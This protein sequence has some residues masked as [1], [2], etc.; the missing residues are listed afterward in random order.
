MTAGVAD[1]AAVDAVSVDHRPTALASGAAVLVAVVTVGF[2][3][4][5]PAGRTAI[6][7]VG[8]GSLVLASLSA[9]AGHDALG[10][11]VT[12]IGAVLVAGGMAVLVTASLASV[13]AA[14]LYPGVLAIAVYGLALR[15]L[16]REWATPLAT[17]AAANLL[18]AV[19]AAGLVQTT[20]RVAL[21]L[22]A[23]GVVASWDAARQAVTL[24]QQVGRGAASNAVAAVHVGGTLLVGLVA[25]GLA[26]LVWS[27][28]VTGLPLPGLLVLLVAGVAFV[29]ALYA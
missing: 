5:A 25:V 21:L 16:K 7:I 9:P 3:V 11:L 2:L 1:D 4:T 12:G 15:P 8:L 22:A 18:L 29:V 10:W 27:V 19:L 13:T 26:E 24:G 23:L 14:V 17:A 6:V 28:G 20:G